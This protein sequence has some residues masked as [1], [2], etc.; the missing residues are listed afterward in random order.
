MDKTLFGWIHLSDIHFGHGDAGHGWDQELVMSALR[1][2]IASKPAPVRVDAVFVTGDIAFS[3][4][5]L[6]ADEYDRARKWLLEV[7][8]AAGVGPERI[9]L[10][11]GNHDVNRGVDG[12]NKSTG[13]LMKTLRSRGTPEQPLDNALKDAGDR[14]HLTSRMEKYLA[15]SKDFG[16]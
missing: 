11:P 12:T 15:F 2:D 14:K 7:G 16:H 9:F 3:G 4:A 10:V 1:R 8:E 13:R 5:G 6:S